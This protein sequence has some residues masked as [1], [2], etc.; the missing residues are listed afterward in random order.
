MTSAPSNLE[1]SVVVVSPKNELRD[2]LQGS[3]SSMRWHVRE[4][5]GGAEAMAHLEE[6]S[7]EAL[8]VDEWL[9]D[10]EVSGFCQ[11]LAELYPGLDIVLVGDRSSPGS[12]RSPRRHELQHALREAEGRTLYSDKVGSIGRSE[13]ELA[14]EIAEPESKEQARS[15]PEADASNLQVSKSR[16]KLPLIPGLI[17]G[18]E[19][20][21]ELSRLIS[22]VASHEARVLIE[23]ETGTGKE[24][25]AKAIHSM[26]KRSKQPFI[27]LNCAAIPE[28]L[29]EAELFGHT[30]GAFTGAVQSRVG[31]IEAAHGG[32]LFLDEIGE[33]PFALQAKLLRFLENG[34]VQR[35][36]E[37]EATQV[38]VRVLAATHQDLD[39]CVL[40]RT[41]RLD[42]LHRL[43]V[44]PIVVPSLRERLD[45]IE[46]LSDYLLERLGR[47]TGRK[48][49]T[50]EALACLRQHSWPGNVRE[51]GHVIQRAAILSE[52]RTE[53]TASDIR[54][55]R[56]ERRSEP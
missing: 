49:L 2:R 25:V 42:L 5:R 10:L 7:A 36:G 26:S 3:L 17:G 46:L 37:N 47:E 18:S 21:R 38:N 27:V 40:E 23:G 28:A 4:A 24:L 1:R 50:Q 51:L 6:S 8:I 53:I 33:M 44:F 20:M 34:E 54:V 15:L 55:R 32:T 39:K 45:D 43:S 56:Q 52:D 9:P 22:L 14:V 31:R 19:A 13:K 41:F 29:L 12:Y 30:R 11:V 48:R 16:S 35:V